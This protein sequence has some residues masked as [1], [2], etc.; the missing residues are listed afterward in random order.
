M[1]VEFPE[2]CC[3]EEYLKRRRTK[4]RGKQ[5]KDLRGPAA[6]S[7]KRMPMLFDS[8]HWGKT[9]KEAIRACSG[10]TGRS[11]NA[12]AGRPALYGSL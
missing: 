7:A 5:V 1:S 6:V 10:K 8:G 4:L 2:C 3:A 9:R 12:R 11:D